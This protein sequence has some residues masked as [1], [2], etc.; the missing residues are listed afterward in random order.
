M[1][2]SLGTL[3]LNTPDRGLADDALIYACFFRN[4]S[5][6][7]A[8]SEGAMLALAGIDVLTAA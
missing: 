3:M 2:G 7:R 1:Q 4:T 5:R 8:A 6:R